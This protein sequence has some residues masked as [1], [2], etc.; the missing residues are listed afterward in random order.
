[1]VQG[2]GQGPAPAGPAHGVRLLAEQLDHV[3]ADQALPGGTGHRPG[4]VDEA[5]DP[6]GLLGQCRS[7]PVAVGVPAGRHVQRGGGGDDP[8]EALLVVHRAEG[9]PVA[10]AEAGQDGREDAVRP[11]VAD[12]VGAHVELVLAPAPEH[13]GVAPGNVVLFEDEHPAPVGGQVGRADQSAEAAADHDRVV[14]FLA[15]SGRR[16]LH[17]PHFRPHS[18]AHRKVPP[19]TWISKAGPLMC[20]ARSD[21]REETGS[22]ASSGLPTRPSATFPASVPARPRAGRRPCRRRSGRGDHDGSHAARAALLGRGPGESG[23]PRLKHGI[24]GAGDVTAN[25]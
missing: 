15:G 21:G 4:D 23:D 2:L 24:V 1:M 3:V 25:P 7:E 19:R 11:A 17:F 10:D 6:L 12:V 16:T 20:A 8:V 5:V 13:V 18:S 22:A 14:A 9:H